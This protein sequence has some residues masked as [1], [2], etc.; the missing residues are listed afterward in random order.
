M[1]AF[2]FKGCLALIILWA[3]SSCE[4][5]SRQSERKYA[6]LSTE[7]DA[8][9][10]QGV[11]LSGRFLSAGTGEI[12]EYGFIIGDPDEKEKFRIR[13]E[14][15][16]QSFSCL[17]NW[18]IP[19]GEEFSVKS[20]AI[21]AD[22]SSYGN[23]LFFISQGFERPEPVVESFSP[24]TVTDG[25]VVNLVGSGFSQWK[26]II[27]VSTDDAAC[28]IVSACSDS[29][30][31]TVPALSEG[32]KTFTL[33]IGEK[34]TAFGPVLVSAPVINEFDPVQGY[35]GEVVTI[36]GDYMPGT[37]AVLFGK[38]TAEILESAGDFSFLRVISPA[39]ENKGPVEL[40]VDVSGKRTSS[41]DQYEILS[42]LITEVTPSAC[43]A[44]DILTLSG[45]GFVQKDRSSSVF[46]NGVPAQISEQDPMTIKAYLPPTHIT[47]PGCT[48]RVIN[49]HK[50]VIYTDFQQLSS[51]EQIQDF[52]GSRPGTWCATRSKG[53]A[54]IAMG[55]PDTPEWWE[56]DPDRQSWESKAD[57]PGDLSGG[58]YASFC[59]ADE[60]FV[61]QEY[62]VGGLPARDLW[63]YHPAGDTWTLEQ[64][65]PELIH[66]FNSTSSASLVF[67]NKAFITG[68]NDLKIYDMQN[69]VWE[70]R[71]YPPNEYMKVCFLSGSR[72]FFLSEN[73]LFEYDPAQ[74]TWTRLGFIPFAPAESS[75]SFAM[76]GRFYF[77]GACGSAIQAAR[78]ASFYELDPL[79]LE[80][81]E[82]EDFH[83]F[84]ALQSAF[85][86]EERA[87]VGM[88]IDNRAQDQYDFWIFDP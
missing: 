43:K 71:N 19:E 60:V 58:P 55:Y 12:K 34:I 17:L 38:D 26:E 56:F 74:D 78:S 5:E 36:R 46:V 69:E 4:Q 75:V 53:Y 49:G 86:F 87:F 84:C 14:G 25:S 66:G 23:V 68:E 67:E 77:G 80:V 59:S 2:I 1:K 72:L 3:L 48:I 76:A 51:W 35:D 63:S 24:G 6:V 33:A 8:L 83:R 32:E 15:G 11:Q 44:G 29:I 54:G 41:R 73:E 18:D 40:I 65:P 27:K 79:S 57:F 62:E 30:V 28:E 52:P 85:V 21:S 20:Y 7:I 9:T 42:H 13:M 47:D 61:L 10:P 50:E 22:Y 39:T 16:L 88:G 70:N 81:I 64:K 45:E 82:R 31:F 37:A